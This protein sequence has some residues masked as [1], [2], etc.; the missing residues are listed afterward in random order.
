M[1]ARLPR[2]RRTRGFTL[3]EVMMAL[4]VSL[5]GL[6]GALALTLSMITGGVF[7]RNMTEASTLAQAKLEAINSQVVTLTSPVSSATPV[8]ET[9]LDAYG[10]TVPTGIY[11]RKTTWGVTSDGLRRSIS[12]E[13]DW[14]DSAGL[15]HKV[16]ATEERIP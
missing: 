2:R 5:V 7:A 8:T 1:R 4:G 12:V 6:L 9:T 10:N 14:N 15:P 11:T 13:V 16:Y 3:I